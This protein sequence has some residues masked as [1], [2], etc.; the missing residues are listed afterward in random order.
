M[1]EDEGEDIIAKNEAQILLRGQSYKRSSQTD[2]S[3]LSGEASIEKN[4]HDITLAFIENGYIIFWISKDLFWSWGTGDL[5]KGRDLAIV[6]ET[7]AMFF[8]RSYS[9][10][11]V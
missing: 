5:T 3:I 7:V 4:S 10:L 8:E 2:L 1:P 11:I 6:Y 9:Y